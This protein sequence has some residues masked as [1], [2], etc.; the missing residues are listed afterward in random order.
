MPC[1]GRI[2]GGGPLRKEYRMASQFA[3][4]PRDMRDG[5]RDGAMSVI[6]DINRQ[7]STLAIHLSDI[8]SNAETITEE[9]NEGRAAAEQ[10]K[11]STAKFT[12]ETSALNHEMQSIAG[13]IAVAADDLDQTSSKVRTSLTKTQQLTEAVRDASQLLNN[14][15]ASLVQASKIS[16]EIRA[17][18]LQTNMLALN[19]AI[20]AARAGEAGKG[21]AV[22][23]HEVRQLANKT[24]AAT[25]E[26]DKSLGQVTQSAR[27]L[28][29]QGEDNIKI[30][31]DVSADANA[32][33]SM[34]SQAASQL[35]QI[36]AQSDHIITI[37]NSHERAFHGLTSV[38][39]HVSNALISTSTEIGQA[40]Q[41]LAD[42]SDV[43]ELLLWTI[44]KTDVQT[45]DSAIIH[46]AQHTAQL[47]SAA[48][49]AAVAAGQIS[50]EDL[51]DDR[52][53]EIANTAPSQVLA[54]HTL[55][56]DKV[57]PPFQEPLL[58]YDDRIIFACACDRNGYIATHNQ[59]FSKPQ[60]HDSVWNTANCRN[61]RV[62]ADRVGLA[63]ARN[64]EPMLLHIYRRDMGGGRF[65]LMKHVSSPIT[66]RGRHWGGL[67]CAFSA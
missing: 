35:H 46:A 37:T 66:V 18:A 51:F 39:T 53:R 6:S 41:S 50:L 42:L 40:S 2:G 25:E 28:I 30:A 33:I 7:I 10:L 62:F 43:S 36:K 9:S 44:A 60:G 34:T 4:Q 22:V 17:I 21:F 12:G 29:G 11:L 56:T 13:T 47:I 48:F 14:L 1:L 38:I 26:I 45:D 19:A 52:Y 5:M 3:E 67:R 16:N 61:R 55:F 15:Q 49:E 8:V 64:R 31:A 27:V 57:L 63:A 58:A 65:V 24:Q 54:R 23:A 20:E 32:I 59:V